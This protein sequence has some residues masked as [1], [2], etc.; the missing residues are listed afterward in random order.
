MIVSMGR[1]SRSP[2]NPL[3]L[4]MILRADLMILSRRWAVVSCF[5]AAFLRAV[6]AMSSPSI[7]AV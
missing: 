4:R 5:G 3:S 7:Q 1:R 6:L 2:F